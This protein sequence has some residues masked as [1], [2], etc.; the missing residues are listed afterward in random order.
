MFPNCKPFVVVAL[1]EN[2]FTLAAFNLNTKRGT[3][4]L[5]F[6]FT[7]A[8]FDVRYTLI[9]QY[10]KLPLRSRTNITGSAP[11]Q[12][13]PDYEGS[14]PSNSRRLLKAYRPVSFWKGLFNLI[15]M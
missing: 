1:M 11:R 12:R 6:K 14:L 4:I 10:I 8:L 3:K 2:G 5:G 13:K 15:L 9:N 7:T